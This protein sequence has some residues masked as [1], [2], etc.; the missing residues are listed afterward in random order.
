MDFEK[1]KVTL[2]CYI[3]YNKNSNPVYRYKKEKRIS[4]FQS[5]NCVKQ[6]SEASSASVS[7]GHE[8][9]SCSA[10]SR[11]P[12]T[13]WLCSGRRIENSQVLAVTLPELKTLFLLWCLPIIKYGDLLMRIL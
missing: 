2:T 13:T 3:A 9:R 10:P 4:V 6:D 7:S 12:T 11:A 5:D 1:N 8:S